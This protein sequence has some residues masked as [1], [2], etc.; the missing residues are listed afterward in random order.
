MKI[1]DLAVY[2]PADFMKDEHTTSEGIITHVSYPS[3]G[4][5]NQPMVVIDGSDNGWVPACCVSV[6]KG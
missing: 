1:G 6:I 2:R 4:I 3:D 5:F